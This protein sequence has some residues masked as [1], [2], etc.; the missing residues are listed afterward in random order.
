MKL[1]KLTSL[2]LMSTLAATMVIPA[3]AAAPEFEASPTDKTATDGTTGTTSTTVSSEVNVPTIKVKVPATGSVVLNPYKMK[4]SVNSV[5][6][7]D[8]VLGTVG[9]LSNET[10]GIG[11]SVKCEPTAS[12]VPLVASKDEL[13]DITEKKMYLTLSVEPT[14][15]APTA[16]STITAANAKTIVMTE[17]VST[18]DETQVTEATQKLA[19][20]DDSTA[21]AKKYLL[22]QIGGELSKVQGWSTDDTAEIS[23]AWTFEVDIPTT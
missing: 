19:A 18:L 8:Q 5:D 14:D 9:S 16:S 1:R 17:D 6:K 21:N 23:L 10:N 2:A 3:F 7:T 20:K 12:G 11:I 15:T 13:E 4:V 22:F